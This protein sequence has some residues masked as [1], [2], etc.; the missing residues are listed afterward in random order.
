MRLYTWFHDESRIYLALEIASKGELYKHLKKAPHG[1]FDEKRAAKYTYQ[2]ADALHYCHVNNVIHRDLKP[3]NI[4]LTAE[5]NV[6][7]A[8]FGW[9]AHTISNKRKTMCGTLDYLPPEM[10]DGK[11][12]NDSVD[13]WCLG[14]LCYEFLVGK[15]PF[16]SEGTENTYAKI[17]QLNIA[18]PAYMSFKAKNLISQ[19]ITFRPSPVP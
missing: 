18:Y 14:I 8:D 9:S 6:K 17:R 16:E 10:V 12:Y 19:V 7:L 2:I 1:R 13:Q 11:A 4:M 5:D 3:E 15:P